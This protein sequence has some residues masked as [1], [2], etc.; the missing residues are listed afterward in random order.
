MPAEYFPSEH[1]SQRM[2]D[3]MEQTIPTLR[4]GA[5]S[6]QFDSTPYVQNVMPF[7]QLSWP[8]RTSSR[9]ASTVVQNPADTDTE[10][11]AFARQYALALSL[12]AMHDESPA[13]A[14]RQPAGHCLHT[15]A[16]F[17]PAN[18]PGSQSVH[19]LLVLWSGIVETHLPIPQVCVC[20]HAAARSSTTKCPAEHCKHDVLSA[21]SEKVPPWQSVQMRSIVGAQGKCT[22]SPWT[23]VVQALHEDFPTVVWKK[24]DAHSV[25]ASLLVTLLNMPAGHFEHV[26]SFLVSP[27][28]PAS[29][30]LHKR[31]AAQVLVS[32][33]PT[34]SRKVPSEH[35]IFTEASGQKWPGREEE[36]VEQVS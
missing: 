31:Q 10:T 26:R 6:E 2:S 32:E 7:S 4:P 8:V 9:L 24:P 3:V 28:G 17:V 33:S 19:C 35:R 23:H 22:R 16:L 25:H 11:V 15:A 36:K 1:S 14:W 29:P 12:Q 21:P 20:P 30:S 18:V 13:R 27:S 34:V 5:Q